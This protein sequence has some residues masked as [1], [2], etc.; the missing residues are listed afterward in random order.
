MKTQYPVSTKKSSA[1]RPAA[2]VVPDP[3]PVDGLRITDGREL[4]TMEIHTL[5]AW[6]LFNGRPADPARGHAPIPGG[7]RFAAITKALW[8]LSGNDNPYADWALVEVCEGLSRI[9]TDV[10][11]RIEIYLEELSALRKRGLQYST[12]LSDNPKFVRLGFGSPYGY[13]LAEAVFEYDYFVRLLRTMRMKARVGDEEAKTL[14]RGTARAYRALF[15]A[16]VRWEKVLSRE[17]LR[18]LSR[19]DFAKDADDT[20][21]QRAELAIA[22]LGPVPPEIFTGQ[23]RP[24]HTRRPS[25]VKESAFRRLAEK[26]LTPTERLSK[27]EADL[28]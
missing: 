26:A 1:R 14:I 18:W 12:V 9:R 13:A 24:T 23:L 16:P 28:I 17:D 15:L 7:R 20:A 4:D 10:Q 11:S 25:P 22:E 21:K 19:R 27:R 3:T 6:D 2:P 5:E 8:Y